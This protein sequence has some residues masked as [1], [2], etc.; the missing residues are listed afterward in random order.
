MCPKGRNKKFWSYRMVSVFIA[1]SWRTLRIVFASSS[2]VFGFCFLAIDCIPLRNQKM[3]FLGCHICSWFP[4]QSSTPPLPPPHK[5]QEL[6]HLH[7][8]F[9]RQ[10]H[11]PCEM[12]DIWKWFPNQSDP[13]PEQLSVCPILEDKP[14]VLRHLLCK[15]PDPPPLR[16]KQ[17][18]NVI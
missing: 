4:N 17:K 13:V 2:A 15:Y 18:M 9:P 6:Q 16:H 7:T 14:E 10:Q 11:R 8:R 1:S 5:L 3:T 12:C